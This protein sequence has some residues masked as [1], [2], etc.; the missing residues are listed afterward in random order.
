MEVW[1]YKKTGNIRNGK[2]T[3]DYKLSFLFIISLKDN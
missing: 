1:I 2:Y 3:G